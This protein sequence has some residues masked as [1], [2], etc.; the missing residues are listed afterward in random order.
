MNNRIC[1]GLKVQLEYADPPVSRSGTIL[2]VDA[3]TLVVWLAGDGARD[4]DPAPPL[5]RAE[6]RVSATADDGLYCFISTLLQ[7]CDFLLYLSPPRGIR[8]VQR[9]DDIRQS[10]LFDVEVILP[11]VGPAPAKREQATAINISR[12]GIL[13]VCDGHCGIDNHVEL[14]IRLLDD[15]PPLRVT[16]R[17]VRMESFSHC[18]RDLSRVG[19]CIVG[20]QRADERRL[21]QFIMKCQVKARTATPTA[22]R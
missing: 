11:A 12:S 8:R 16:A 3:Q 21:A 2:R 17:V 9:R 19:L 1:K 22:A 18:G 15:K 4:D 20:L 5:S 10:C 6:V 14:S 7:S 13:L